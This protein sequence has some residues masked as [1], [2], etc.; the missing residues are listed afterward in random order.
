ME[1]LH[2]ICGGQAATNPLQIGTVDS[3]AYISFAFLHRQFVL[4]IIET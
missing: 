1:G 4:S 3:S 2:A